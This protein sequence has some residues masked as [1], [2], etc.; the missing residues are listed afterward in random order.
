MEPY[1]IYRYLVIFQTSR[2]M[3][4]RDITIELNGPWIGFANRSAM[5]GPM[6]HHVACHGNYQIFS[7]DV[8]GYFLIVN[9]LFHDH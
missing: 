6:D 9:D 5:R 8:M 7:Q 2:A 1:G 3:G 4:H